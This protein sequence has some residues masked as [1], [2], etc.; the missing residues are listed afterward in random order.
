M[1]KGL[2]E[3]VEWVLLATGSIIVAVAL[4]YPVVYVATLAVQ[5]AGGIC[6]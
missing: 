5:A 4:T 3:I 6:P 2:P 1:V